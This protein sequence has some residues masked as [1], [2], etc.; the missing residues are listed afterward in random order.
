MRIFIKQ[1]RRRRNEL[2][3]FHLYAPVAPS[4][5]HRLRDCLHKTPQLA[6][7]NFNS[8]QFVCRR[9]CTEFSLLPSGPPIRST[10]HATPHFACYVPL[11]GQD[12]RL[13]FRCVCVLVP[14]ELS[15]NKKKK[16]I[17]VNQKSLLIKAKLALTRSKHYPA[18]NVRLTK[19]Y[20]GISER[21][22]ETIESVLN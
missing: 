15:P 5:S 20:E 7:R 21:K 18:V 14:C 8:N 13:F 2:H 12:C 19:S 6:G 10:V 16:K 1:T 4:R 9:R 17:E 22:Q 11:C 3:I